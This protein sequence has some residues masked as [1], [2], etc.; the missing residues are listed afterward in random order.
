MKKISK[1]LILVLVIYIF[2]GCG[3]SNDPK[4]EEDT[5]TTGTITISAD[6]TLRPLIEAELVA[7]HADYKYAQVNVR[8][9]PEAEVMADLLNDSSKIVIVARK[10]LPNEQKVLEQQSFNPRTTKMAYD[11]I[12]LL[13]NKSNK[14][15]VYSLDE[16]K[17]MLTGKIKKWKSSKG[18]ISLVFDNKNSS[19]A[20]GCIDLLQG[21]SMDKSMVFGMNNSKE[22]LDYVAKNKNALGFI[23]LN[24]ISDVDDKN[25]QNFLKTVTVLNIKGP[26]SSVVSDQY[27]KP[28]MAYLALGYYPLRRDIYII[29]REARAGL[30]SGVAAFIAGPKGQTIIQRAG[31]LPAQTQLR[32]VELKNKKIEIEREKK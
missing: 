29:S 19:I 1:L 2:S 15:T 10:L 18:D 28:H 8:F 22:V 27:F 26:D 11:A 9:K 16:I 14:D 31:L 32:I 5:P 17:Q 3:K 30:G 23:G 6:E 25:N 24:W 21:Q 4:K 7:F 13:V 20:R 12:A